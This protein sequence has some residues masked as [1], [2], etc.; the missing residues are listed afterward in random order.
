MITTRTSK[1]VLQE[2]LVGWEGGVSPRALVSAKGLE[3]LRDEAAVATLVKDVLERNG[4]KV[5]EYR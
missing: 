5:A 4:D 3:A 2:L 1:D